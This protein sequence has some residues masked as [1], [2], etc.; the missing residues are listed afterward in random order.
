MPLNFSSPRTHVGLHLVQFHLQQK[1]LER[2]FFTSLSDMCYIRIIFFRWLNRYNTRWQ[3]II[4]FWHTEDRFTSQWHQS[5]T[6]TDPFIIFF[7]NVL[8]VITLEIC[9]ILLLIAII[10]PKVYIFS[11][12]GICILIFSSFCK[13]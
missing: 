1:Y 8:I 11:D 10:S 5:Q 2:F 4:F 3:Y 6:K 12:I 13:S 9:E 7:L